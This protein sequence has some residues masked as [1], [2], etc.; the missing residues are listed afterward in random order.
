MSKKSKSKKE[1]E[2]EEVEAAE[3]AATEQSLADLPEPEADG[4]PSA[5]SVE[6]P[7]VETVEINTTVTPDAT[8]VTPDA[9]P[10]V[11]P[12]PVIPV[13]PI[14]DKERAIVGVMGRGYTREGAEKIVDEYGFKKILDDLSKPEEPT[15]ILET[16]AE[17][18]ANWEKAKAV[19]AE[20]TKAER[21]LFKR[22]ESIAHGGKT[23][24]TVSEVNFH[25]NIQGMQFENSVHYTDA[26][27]DDLRVQRALLIYSG[28]KAEKVSPAK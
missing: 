12:D 21:D 5:A 1:I 2:T 9:I 7:S 19:L 8:S 10:A 15:V 18:L 17:A 14:S 6:T 22:W 26:P 3:N 16:P 13:A 4:A 11:T 24:L 28:T 20:A 27:I 25:N 23:K